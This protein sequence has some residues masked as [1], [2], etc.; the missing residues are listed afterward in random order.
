MN[1]DTVI[2]SAV[3]HELSSEIIGARI[4]KIA[5]PAP[6]ELVISLYLDGSRRSL[7]ISAEPA[8]ARVHLVRGRSRPSPVPPPAFCML[9]RKYMEAGVV[10]DV[11]QPLGVCERVL[12]ISVRSAERV[13]VDLF[14]ELM[15]RQ[16]N[17]ILVSASGVILGSIKRV[18]S[19]MSR[20][21]EVRAGISYAAPPK[22]LGHKRDPMEPSSS[23]G[24]PAM[25]FASTDEAA[26]WLTATFRGVGP[27]LA[28]EA[29]LRSP[30]VPITTESA[31]YGLNDVLNIVR[32]ADYLPVVYTNSNKQI[33][34]AY[35]FRLRS[36]PEALQTAEY[37]MSAALDLAY[38][39]QLV[40]DTFEKQRTALVAS[41][42]KAAKTIDRQL[43]DAQEGLLNSEQS[44]YLRENGE[45]LLA[46]I[47]RQRAGAKVIAV[48]DYFAAEANI[49]REI[50]L[51]PKLN[52]H[53]NAERYFRRYQ[54]ARDSKDVLEQRQAELQIAEVKLARGIDSAMSAENAAQLQSISTELSAA[55]PTIQTPGSHD[56]AAKP[57]YEGHKV[58]AMKTPDGWEILVG[59]NS[60]S[61]DYLT[62]KVASPND[63]WLHARAVPSAHAVIRAQ[64]RPASV[65]TAAILLAAEQVARRSQAKHAGLV[66]VDYTLKKYV[67]K[68]R[69][70]APGQVTYTNEKT[71]DVIAGDE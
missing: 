18:T 45:L 38:G 33:E 30:A 43:L 50:E 32:T 48:P 59:E 55:L 11:S 2:L 66:S 67:R 37:T 31:W 17:I 1:F 16:S 46:N 34:G 41:L 4:D 44:E 35:P 52:I 20:L 28:Q 42:R 70:S 47:S 21:R 62:T 10:L 61:N 54:K 22:Q 57:A 56:G 58:K 64:N 5:Q 65:S 7:L 23:F 12:K 3:T 40:D 68:P 14:I 26:K 71:I 39:T 25:E 29:A 53:E 6:L 19:E 9:L 69:G 15:G 36:V 13:Y 51:D 27:L 8:S 24:L 63:I 49:T 60:T